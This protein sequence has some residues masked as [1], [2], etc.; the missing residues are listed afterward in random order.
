MLDL[1]SY[2]ILKDQFE[3]NDSLEERN[4]ETSPSPLTNL[5]MNSIEMEIYEDNN[6]NKE[7]ELSRSNLLNCVEM[8]GEYLHDIH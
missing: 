5:E 1:P 4:D 3:T 7:E 2:S 6:E 8:D